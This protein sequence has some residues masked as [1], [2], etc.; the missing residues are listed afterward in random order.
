M[1]IVRY[2]QAKGDER[3]GCAQA[4]CEECQ[5]VLIVEHEDLVWAVVKRQH[6]GLAEYGDV[7]QEGRIGCWQAVQYYEPSRG[8]RFSTLAWRLIRFRI[9]SAVAWASKDEGFLVTEAG[10]W[11]EEQ[12]VEDWQVRELR[13][14]LE[15]GMANLSEQQRQVVKL[16][17]NWDGVRPQTFAE[18]GK[19]W[20]FSRQ[21]VH[22][23]HEEALILLRTPGL[24]LR[25]RSLYERDSREEYRAALQKNWKWQRAYRGRK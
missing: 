24:S 14:A 15:Q 1:D 4:G 13:V 2:C 12:I 3:F 20:G 8:L 18:I 25:L 22:Q 7:M 5:R 17:V 11:P 19:L 9:R 16:H 21:R 6:L 10:K 23:I